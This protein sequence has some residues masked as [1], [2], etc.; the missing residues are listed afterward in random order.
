M[1]FHIAQQ[2]GRQLELRR[3]QEGRRHAEPEPA[4]K[5]VARAAGKNH[6]ARAQVGAIGEGHVDAVAGQFNCGN[7]YAADEG[8]AGG[9]RP[10]AESGIEDLAID[11]DRFG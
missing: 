8:C 6:R 2:V 7:A 4:L 5:S 1:D 11:H 10:P 9:F 3:L